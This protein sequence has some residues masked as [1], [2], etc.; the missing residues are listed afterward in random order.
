[1]IQTYEFDGVQE[2]GYIPIPHNLADKISPKFKV[3][4]VE[5]VAG[6]EEK[7]DSKAEFLS[8]KELFT[9]SDKLMEENRK[10]YEV[11]AQ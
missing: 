2:K 1:M 11:L 10:V 6:K 4:L 8:D 5:E 3:I 9:V 7:Y